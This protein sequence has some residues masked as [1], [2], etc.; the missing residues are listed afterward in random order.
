M[1]SDPKQAFKVSYDSYGH[2]E[3]SDGDLVEITEGA[4][5]DRVA[6]AK[7]YSCTRIAGVNRYCNDEFCGNTRCVQAL[8]DQ[9]VAC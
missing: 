8:C 7:N 2:F 9:N 1:R 6:G 4:A 5:L 3:I